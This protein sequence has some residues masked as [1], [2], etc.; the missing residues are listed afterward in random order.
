MSNQTP[1]AQAAAAAHLKLIEQLDIHSVH[2]SFRNTHWRPN[3]RRNK[4]IKTILGD[5]QRKEASSILAT[6]QDASGAATPAPVGDDSLSTSGTST[7]VVPSANGANANG[8]TAN[9]AQASRSLS[10]LVLEKSLNVPAK[11]SNGL[12]ASLSSAPVATYTN[13]E[14]APSLAPMKRYCDITGLSAPYIDPK[15]RLRYHNA[16]VFA[17]IRSLPQGVGE[18]FLE[19]RGAHTVLK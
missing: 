3:Q 9:L 18:Q 17:M 19:A 13:I 14:S 16:E 8:T 11:G 15:T 12:A 2:K 6:P 5:A 4:N 7:P 1:E 10:K